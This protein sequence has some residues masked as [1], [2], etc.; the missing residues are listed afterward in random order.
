MADGC[1]ILYLLIGQAAFLVHTSQGWLGE[2]MGSKGS[3]DPQSSL[4]AGLIK[5]FFILFSLPRVLPPPPH[6]LPL[7]PFSS[8]DTNSWFTLWK[9]GADPPALRRVCGGGRRD[10]RDPLV[11]AGCRDCRKGLLVVG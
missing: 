1:S 4:R 9:F 10:L 11:D 8:G 6:S 7:H 3:P 2:E 5:I